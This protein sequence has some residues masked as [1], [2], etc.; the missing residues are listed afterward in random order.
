MQPVVKTK[1][2]T[3]SMPLQKELAD[4]ST[5]LRWKRPGV[6]NSKH[7][8]VRVHFLRLGHA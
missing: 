5:H 6:T 8:M 3:I 1:I 7:G 2:L 4:P